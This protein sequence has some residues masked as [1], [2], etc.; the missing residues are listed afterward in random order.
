LSFWLFA[1]YYPHQIA[2][3]PHASVATNLLHW[4]RFDIT[5]SLGFDVPAAVGNVVL[6]ILVARPVL[7]AL[8]R[9]ARR[10]AFDA[11]VDFT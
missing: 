7:A 11:P 3:L 10:V 4:W 1:R 9:V 8:R 5:T 2:F 6:V